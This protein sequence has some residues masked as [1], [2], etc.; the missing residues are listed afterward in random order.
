MQVKSHYLSKF[1]KLTEGA[2]KGFVLRGNLMIVEKIEFEVKTASGIYLNAVNN[3]H[4]TFGLHENSPEY[5]VVV[6]TGEGY[7]DGEEMECKVGD[8]VIIPQGGVN[9]LS[10]FGSTISQE[11]KTDVLGIAR[12]SDAFMV[13][14]GAEGFEK[15]FKEL[16]GK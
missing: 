2:K 16:E 7:E 6:Q 12:S 8:V 5:Y 10:Y 9:Y 14:N 15:F 13:F 4:K 11:D 3:K 1:S